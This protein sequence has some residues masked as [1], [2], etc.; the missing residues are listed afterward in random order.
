MAKTTQKA[1]IFS[2]RES[3][4]KFRDPAH[5]IRGREVFGRDG[6]KMGTI[7][8]VLMD[9]KHSRIR[10]IEVA[11]GG[12]LQVFGRDTYILPV[13]MIT[14]VEERKVH[15]TYTSEEID[16]KPSYIPELEEGQDTGPAGWFEQSPSGLPG[17]AIQ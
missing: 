1:V 15:V 5:D 7:E 6:K 17:V 10:F 14:K 16:R 13:N 3:G 4:M 12:F 2:L 8:D 11:H 9:D